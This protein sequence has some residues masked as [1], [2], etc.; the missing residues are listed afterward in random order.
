[1]KKKVLAAIVMF[2]WLVVICVFMLLAQQV[3]LEIFF[4]LWL[5]GI[6]VIVELVDTRFSLPSYLRY[7][8]YLVAAGIVLF[9]GIVAQKI[10]EILAK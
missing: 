4:V 2:I 5:I 10:L 9:G 7:I 6:L 3:D 1:M 8:K